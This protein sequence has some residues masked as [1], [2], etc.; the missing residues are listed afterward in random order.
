MQP[1]TTAG[2]LTETLSLPLPKQPLKLVEQQLVLWGWE[3][4]APS[5]DCGSFPFQKL[6]TSQHN[7]TQHNNISRIIPGSGVPPD[8]PAPER[9]RRRQVAGEQKRGG[10][11]SNTLGPVSSPA[12][13]PPSQSRSHRL[14]FVS[15]SN[16]SNHPGK[17]GAVGSQVPLGC[18]LPHPRSPLRPGPSLSGVGPANGRRD[19]RVWSG[20]PG[21]QRSPPHSSGRGPGAH[22]RGLSFLRSP[23]ALTLLPP[24]ALPPLPVSRSSFSSTRRPCTAPGSHGGHPTPHRRAA[25]P[26]VP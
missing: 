12:R 16:Y 10:K 21:V 11:W 23:I 1:L 6:G 25:A 9:K 15:G 14:R 22:G 18:P 17:G 13:I 7:T 3:L 20:S 2:S 26:R 24:P 4:E 19:S 8:S 5:K